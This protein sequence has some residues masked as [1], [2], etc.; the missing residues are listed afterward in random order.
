MAKA[1]WR[2]WIPCG[3]LC[4]Q[5]EK[6]EDAEEWKIEKVEDTVTKTNEAR[7]TLGRQEKKSRP[8]ERAAM[9][10]GM[11]GRL[12]VFPLKTG[13]LVGDAGAIPLGCS[14]PLASTGIGCARVTTAGDGGLIGISRADQPG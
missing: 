12:V 9:G 14:Y 2:W 7:A 8:G 13:I 11:G 5:S 1:R 10:A 6:A 4:D 3:F